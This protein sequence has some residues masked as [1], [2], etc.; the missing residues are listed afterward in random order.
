[1][2][3]MP[4]S[5]CHGD[6]CY[7]NLF[8]RR[9]ADGGDQTVVIDW[10]YAGRRQ[11]GGDMAGLIADSSILPVRRKAAEPE[12]FSE[13]ILESYLSGLRAAGW[14]GDPRIARFAC[15]ATLALPWSIN[16]LSSLN[17]GIL[18][19]PLSDESRP[20]LAEKLEQYAHRQRFLLALAA[21]ARG[22]LEVVERQL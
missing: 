17:G 21:E 1:L 22:L 9:L 20:Q 16:L 18:A 12:E 11:I 13:M 8:A 19:Q 4:R 15:I 7:P 5:L 3:R 14:T 6:F 10:Q 2:D